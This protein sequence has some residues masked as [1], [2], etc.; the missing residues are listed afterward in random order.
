M[1]YED[2]VN[3][4]QKE[5]NELPL[6]FA[7]SNE[8][9]EKHLQER[10]ATIKDIYKLGDTGGFYLKKD[11]P[12]I[13]A[14]FGKKDDLLDLMKDEEFAV[15]AFY[16]EMCNHEYGINWQGDWDVCNCFTRG[17][18][19]Y[20]EQKSFADYL[21]EAGMAWLIPA[22]SKAQ[23]QYWEAAEKYEWF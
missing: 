15:D 13:R 19:D 12:I 3:A 21:T 23:T 16:Y 14:Y 22:Y 9:L 8:Q 11:A 5:V 10:N 7:F 6:F 20:G 2:Y 18:P 4:R 17:E 1:K